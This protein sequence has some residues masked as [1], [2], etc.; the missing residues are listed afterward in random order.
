MKM[1]EQERMESCVDSM[2]K[3]LKMKDI[4]EPTNFVLEQSKLMIHQL[5]LHLMKSQLFAAEVLLSSS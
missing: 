5:T 1:V 2:E 4:A 3:H